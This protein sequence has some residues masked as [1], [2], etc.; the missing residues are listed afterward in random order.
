M[1]P[2][3]IEVQLSSLAGLNRA[4][5][6]AVFGTHTVGAGDDDIYLRLGLLDEGVR[7]WAAVLWSEARAEFDRGNAEHVADVGTFFPLIGASAPQARGL[8]FLN[9]VATDAEIRR[10]T[11][12][13]LG[14]IVEALSD[15]RQPRP[16]LNRCLLDQRDAPDRVEKLQLVY[17]LKKYAGNRTAVARH[18]ALHRDTLYHRLAKHNLSGF[19]RPQRA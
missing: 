9:V 13:I 12:F 17:L 8:V 2:D 7:D 5:R 19:G 6:Y 3:E 1:P 10:H 4:S 16:F 11:A 18:L 14:R 15:E